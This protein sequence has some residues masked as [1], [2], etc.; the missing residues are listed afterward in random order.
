MAGR[1]WLTFALVVSTAIASAQDYPAKPI[2]LVAPYPAGGPVDATARILAEQLNL[3]QKVI[4]D[5]RSGAG[6][7]VGAES[8]ARA[9]PDGYTL[10][11]GNS[12][13]ITINPVLRTNLGYDPLKDLAPV[14]WLT[15]AQMVLMVHPS[16]PVRSVQQLV[17]LAKAHPGEL[18]YGSAGIGNTTHLGM[19][20]F[21]SVAELGEGQLQGAQALRLGSLDHQLVVA[22]RLVD[23]EP[24]MRDDLQA[25]FH[26]ELE[27]AIGAA[28]H[29]RAQLGT[30]VLEGEIEMSGGVR[31][32]I[33]DFAAHPNRGV[34]R[35]QKAFQLAGDFGDAVKGFPIGI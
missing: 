25:V 18:N 29:H 7:S 8:V 9:A 20:L 23:A 27:E 30:F 31:V 12:G 3:G 1:G 22:A 21:Q 17:A 34:T 19:E 32:K 4:V 5:N 11:L 33:A 2:R 10:L 28:E 26:L 13:P 15:A 6:G 35:F 16:V 24:A 14:T